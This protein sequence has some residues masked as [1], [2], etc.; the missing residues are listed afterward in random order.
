LKALTG[1]K[2][3]AVCRTLQGFGRPLR[4]KQQINLAAQIVQEALAG[5]FKA[6]LNFYF[7]LL[8]LNKSAYIFA[9]S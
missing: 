6:E 8:A 2:V 9:A 1:R 4:G 5:D 7:K 3:R